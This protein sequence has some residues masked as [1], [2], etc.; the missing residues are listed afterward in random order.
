MDFG[1]GIL[2]AYFSAFK[3]C[4]SAHMVLLNMYERFYFIKCLLKC[5]MF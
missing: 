3:R 4:L 5:V 2:K 1:L